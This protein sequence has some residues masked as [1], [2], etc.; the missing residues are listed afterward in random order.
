MSRFCLFLKSTTWGPLRIGDV[1][2]FFALNQ[3]VGVD[4]DFG[5]QSRDTSGGTR[6]HVP[7]Q[8]FSTYGWGMQFR[9]AYVLVGS[10]PGLM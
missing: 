6:T 3:H 1:S 10:G 2:W 8:Y 4:R 9:R 7:R 5:L